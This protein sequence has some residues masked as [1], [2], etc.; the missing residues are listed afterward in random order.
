MVRGVSVGLNWASMI[1]RGAGLLGSYCFSCCFFI[2][3]F[4]FLFFLS[5]LKM[6]KPRLVLTGKKQLLLCAGTGKD[7]QNFIIVKNY[8]DQIYNCPSVSRHHGGT[9]RAL[10]HPFN[11]T[12]LSYWGAWGAP[13]FWAP[14]MPRDGSFSDSEYI[15]FQSCK[16]PYS[17]N[18]WASQVD[19]FGYFSSQHCL[20]AKL[21][22]PYLHVLKMVY[23]GLDLC[24]VHIER[25]VGNEYFVIF[26]EFNWPTHREV[27]FSFVLK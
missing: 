23:L 17:Q 13:W 16:V 6:L 10:S 4:F 12:V 26:N 25:F 21:R 24:I 2:C 5:G 3:C 8:C 20:W 1:P 22:R 15:F 18:L 19:K 14:I 9:M 11:I 7:S 27:G